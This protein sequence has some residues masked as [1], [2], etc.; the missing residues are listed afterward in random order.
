MCKQHLKPILS[1]YDFLLYVINYYFIYQL[2]CNNDPQILSD[3][4]CRILS[5]KCILK[6]NIMSEP[7]QLRVH[8]RSII[9]SAINYIWNTMD[10]SL[11]Q[12]FIKLANEVNRINSNK[13]QINNYNLDRIVCLDVKQETTRNSLQDNFFNG[14]VFN[15][16]NVESTFI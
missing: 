9:D 6:T 10:P 15:G 8:D 16:R 13:I 2:P 5:G 14:F 12:K 7:T 3:Q 1:I 4:T 11:Q